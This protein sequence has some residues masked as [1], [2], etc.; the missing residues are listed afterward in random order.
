MQ[1]RLASSSEPIWQWYSVADI[2]FLLWLALLSRQP[3][4][5]GVVKVGDVAPL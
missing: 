2:Q 4:V 3:L 1:Y 5:C